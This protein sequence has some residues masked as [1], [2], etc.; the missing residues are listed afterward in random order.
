MSNIQFEHKLA[1]HCESGTVAAL[2]NHAGVAMTEPMAFG[3]AGA[4]FFGYLKTRMLPFPMLAVRNQPGKIRVNLSKYL[5]VKF[6]NQQFRDPDKAMA[7]LDALLDQGIPAALQVNFFDMEY[8]PPYARAHFN[9]HFMVVVGKEDDKYIVSDAYCPTLARLKAD[10]LRKARFAKGSFAPKGLMFHLTKTPDSIDMERAIRKGIKHAVFYM[11]KLP[12]PFLGV[13]GIHYFANKV[14][15]W[16]KITGTEDRLAH[17][18]MMINVLMEDRGT[19]GGGFRFLY[20]SFLQEA[21]EVLHEPGLED[22]AKRMMVNG[23]EWRAISVHAARMGKRRDLGTAN[24]AELS[25]MIH[26]RGHV[27]RDLFLELAK[28]GK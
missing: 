5:G 10:S 23:D 20:A 4:A 26:E 13:K 27:E 7:A 25:D 8:V 3:I 17:E 21:A 12:I 15:E 22:L 19:G 18:I 28:Y 14:I 1:A 24:L 11:L 9:G 16:P 2:L 6:E